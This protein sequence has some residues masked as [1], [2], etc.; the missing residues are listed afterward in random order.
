MTWP[1]YR[2]LNRFWKRWPP[3]IISS[4]ISARLPVRS[5]DSEPVDPS[6]DPSAGVVYDPADAQALMSMFG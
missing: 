3:L 2:A 6:A 1:E 5:D 4:A